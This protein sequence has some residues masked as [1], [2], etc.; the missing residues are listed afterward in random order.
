MKGITGYL[1]GAIALMLLGGGGLVVSR[2][3]GQI[4]EAQ[5]SVATLQYEG[6]EETLDNVEWYFDYVARLLGIGSE[7]LNDVRAR[8]AALHYWQRQYSS[9]IPEQANPVGAV[10]ADNLELQ[11]MVANAVY[12]MGR[13]EATDTATTLQAIETGIASYEIVLRN[14]TRHETAAYN[15]EY[16]VRLRDAIDKVDEFSEEVEGGP[17]GAQ[18]GA[19]EE[20]GADDFKIRVPLENEEMGLPGTGSPIQ[21]QG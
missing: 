5:Q 9:I 13:A 17:F 16:L 1:C 12:R 10:A 20:G 8:K 3:E 18:G 6:V 19:P 15:Y 14:A 4:A 2:L 7:R 11:L 21:R